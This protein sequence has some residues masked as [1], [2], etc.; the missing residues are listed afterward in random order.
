MMIRRFG[1]AD[2]F[3]DFD[4]DDDACPWCE[5]GRHVKWTAPGD[6]VFLENDA[7]AVQRITC[8]WPGPF[9]LAVLCEPSSSEAAT[10]EIEA[11]KP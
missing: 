10:L 5:A 6:V 4:P 1:D 7:G 11:A 3:R 9:P 2:A 8:V